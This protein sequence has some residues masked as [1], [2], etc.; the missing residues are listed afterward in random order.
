MSSQQNFFRYLLFGAR[1]FAFRLT[2]PIIYADRSKLSL[3]VA[4]TEK[5]RLS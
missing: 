1:R 4:K 3:S 2:T 5:N